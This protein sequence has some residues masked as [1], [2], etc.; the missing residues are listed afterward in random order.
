MPSPTAL[1]ITALIISIAS[2]GL[3]CYLALRD[4]SNVQAKCYARLHDRT[5]EYSSIF[6]TV[7]NAGRRRVILR[8]LMGQYEDGSKGGQRLT[9]NGI[10]LEEG[11]FY[12]ME[13]GKFDGLM[14]NGD[15]MSGL[16]EVY[17]EDSAGKK[18]PIKDARQN[19]KTIRESKHPFGTRTHGG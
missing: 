3:S 12:E 11:E 18:Y 4:R 1:S 7:T 6:V 10:T 9:E 16:V 19:V 8:Y 15:E 5:G 2:F 17:F 14:V 13:F